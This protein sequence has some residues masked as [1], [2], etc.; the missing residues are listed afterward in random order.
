MA[1]REALAWLLYI[2][3][4]NTVGASSVLMEYHRDGRG[5]NPWEPFVWEY[6]SGLV[7][8]LLIPVIVGLD[9]RF[10]LRPP[11]WKKSLAVHCIATVP[12]SALHVVVM[13][14]IRKVVYA[15][16]GKNYD[17]GNIP[18]EFL[19][20]YRKDFL[21]YFFVLAVIYGYRAYRA[22][23]MGASY[24]RDTPENQGFLIKK[25]GETL[26]I[27]ITDILWIEAAGNYVLLHADSGTH[28]LRDTM[29]QVEQHVGTGFLRI[30]RSTIVNLHRVQRIHRTRGGNLHAV[31]DNGHKLKCSRNAKSQLETALAVT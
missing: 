30:H 9:R 4:A 17:F 26:R 27:S 1:V 20:E 31:L 3:L 21:T 22:K 10:P 24:D 13:V 28:P 11:A 18:Y 7:I 15:L 19:Y 29:K 25:N 14:G 12:F 5:I 8:L 23:T 6:S 2:L 16:N